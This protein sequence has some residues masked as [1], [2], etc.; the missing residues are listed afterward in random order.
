MARKLSE[1]QSLRRT[2]AADPRRQRDYGDAWETIARA[3]TSLSSYERE[4]RF[5]DGALGFNS[6]LFTHARTLVRL[7]EESAKPNAERLPEYTD[8]RRKSLEL[9]LYSPA[10]IY[11][12]YEQTKLADSLLFMQQELGATN[13]LVTKIL[14]GKPPQQRAAELIAGSRLQ[15]VAYRRQLSEGGRAAVESSDDETDSTRTPR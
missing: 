9:A 6:T 2:V 4:R 12:D 15:D 10:P 1:E 7:A 13:P 5:L 8:A 3:R 14:D 11:V